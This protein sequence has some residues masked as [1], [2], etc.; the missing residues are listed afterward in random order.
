MDRAMENDWWSF[1]SQWSRDLLASEDA[2]ELFSPEVIESGWV[3]CPPASGE[4]IEAAEWRLAVYLPPTYR[5]FLKVSNGWPMVGN[6]FSGGL[7]P[8]EEIERFSIRNPE[9]IEA[10][11]LLP[12]NPDVEVVYPVGNDAFEAAIEI[13][14]TL[15]GSLLLNP[16]VVD[17]DGEMEAWLFEP[18]IGVKRYQSFW[19]LMQAEYELF[20]HL[21]GN[22]Q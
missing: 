17:A 4:Q 14:E 6:P 7:R 20:R 9:W 13:S 1:L 15:E 8:V 21:E 10:I 22:S 16:L 3:G 19:A 2:A 18:E 12:L 11:K 5:E